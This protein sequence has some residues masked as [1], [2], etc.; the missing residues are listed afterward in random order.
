M[1]N[2]ENSNVSKCI[3]H[4]VGNSYAGDK[5][6]YSNNEIIL[7]EYQMSEIKNIF[8]RNFKSPSKTAQ[9]Y[10]SID[11]NQNVIYKIAE[12]IFESGKNYLKNSKNIVKYLFEQSTHYSIKS[13]EVFIL[14]F[15]NVMRNNIVSD[16][17]GIF[18]VENPTSFIKP[19]YDGDS[20]S[21]YFDKGIIGKNIEKGCLIFNND[22]HNGYV[23]YNYEKNNADTNYWSKNFLSIKPSE[24]S[25]NKTNSLLDS[26]REF[27]IHN[28]GDESFSKKDKIDLV[29]KSIDFL[30]EADS[31]LNVN[32]FIKSN[33]PDKKTQTQYSKYLNDYCELNEIQISDKFE[34]SNDAVKYQKKK[35]KSVIKLDRNFHIYIHG[36]EKLIENG[37][38]NG[39]K[40]YKIYYD[41]EL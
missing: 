4:W 35:F 23:V 32:D 31:L 8:T 10:H 5:S 25:F 34:T 36:N 2:L 39:K 9:F 1:I 28:L 33:L 6:I 7:D 21:I 12:S 29:N 37:I 3:V 20:I 24:D 40:F 14:K 16:A 30:V 41:N 15:Q 19:D 18:K 13:G 17:I 11:L 26:Y 38:E 22:Y 27:V